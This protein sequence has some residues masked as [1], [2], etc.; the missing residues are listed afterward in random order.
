MGV[1]AYSRV[2]KGVVS[3]GKFHYGSELIRTVHTYHI[4][5]WVSGGGAL[6]ASMDLS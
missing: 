2:V 3:E 5:Q 6:F 1:Y 4:G